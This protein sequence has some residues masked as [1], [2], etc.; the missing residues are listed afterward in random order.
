MQMKLLLENWRKFVAQEENLQEMASLSIP[1]LAKYA[2][3]KYKDTKRN[4]IPKFIEKVGKG[5][6]F[7]LVRGGTVVIDKE[8]IDNN[9]KTVLQRLIDLGKAG[10]DSD[11]ATKLFGKDRMLPKIGGGSI[12]ITDLKKTAEFGGEESERRTA[13]EAEAMGEL[14]K[15]IKSA[16]KESSSDSIVFNIKDSKNNTLFIVDGVVGVQKQTSIKGV[17]PKADFFLTGKNDEPLLF[18]SHKAGLDP[19]SFGQWGGITEKAGS[20][21]YQHPEVVEFAQQIKNSDFV[22]K[23]TIKGKQYDQIKIGRAHV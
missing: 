7:E 15:L 1:E 19:N 18:I 12:R 5:E 21:I 3:E 13:K 20:K 4:R 16:M 9:G 10:F 23:V 8:A 22:E 2:T 6:P 11:E 14:D 17:D